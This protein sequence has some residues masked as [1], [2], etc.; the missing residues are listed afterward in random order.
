MSDVA[1][2]LTDQQTADLCALADGTLPAD[3]R[4]AVEAWVAAS[5]ELQELLDRQRRS[6]A[7]TG[8]AASEPEPASLRA[9]VEARVAE[10]RRPRAR[11][12]VPRLAFAGAAA[13]AVVVVLVLALGGGAGGPT[14][15]QAAQLAAR[16]PT[17]PAPARLDDSRTQLAVGV[18]GARFPDFRRA[19]GW[20][21]AGVRRG[22]VDGRDATVV[23]YRKGGSRV[24]Y[25]IVSG[26]ALAR[27]GAPGAVRRGVEYQT[28]RAEGRPAV[29]WRRVGHTCVLTG[30]ASRA[31]LLRLAS[32]RGGGALA[33]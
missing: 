7:A 11:A 3:R 4:S 1:S 33:Y 32:W 6:L 2:R 21:P 23:Y 10:R 12:L 14:V 24:A 31:E 18:E 22:V 27:P 8:A 16:P 15:A 13:A 5:P 28:V 29:T 25:V 26:S 30:A 20:R 19:Y 17:G 9:A